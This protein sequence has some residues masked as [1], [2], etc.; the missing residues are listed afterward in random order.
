M[1]L[2]Q[3]LGFKG[4]FKDLPREDQKFYM[5]AYRKENPDRV[6]KWQATLRSKYDPIKQSERYKEYV[7]RDRVGFNKRMA[8]RRK[9]DPFWNEKQR[10]RKRPLTDE[11]RAKIRNRRNKNKEVFLKREKAYRDKNRVGLR[12]W[13][14]K[15]WKK[16][17][18]SEPQFRISHRLRTRLYELLR[19]AEHT[20]SVSLKLDKASLVAHIEKQFLPGMTWNNHGPVWHIDHIIPCSVFDLTIKEQREYCFSLINLRPLWAKENIRKSDSIPDGVILPF[21]LKAV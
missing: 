15:N 19:K 17:Y 3:R 1:T 2:L 10:L 7:S 13:Y 9:A 14:N 6:K 12:K 8:E 5:R 11:S 16:R 18:Y 4:R 21:P 20:E